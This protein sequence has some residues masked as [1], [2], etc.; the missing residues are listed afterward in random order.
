MFG[1]AVAALAMAPGLASADTKA[2]VGLHYNNL[3]SDAFTD[4]VDG[5][6]LDGAFN[7]DFSNGWTLQGDGSSDRLD[8]GGGGDL[9]VS[10][11]AINLGMRTDTH[12]IYG[13]VG[14]ADVFAASA[15]HIGIGGQLYMSN[16]VLEGSV[17]MADIDG[18][19][20]S[21]VN[22]SAG[23][24]WYFNDNLGVSGRVSHTDADGF[25]GPNDDYN[26]IG[27][28]GEYRF[29]NSPVSAFIGF[30]KN[31]TDPDDV[32]TWSLGM[33]VD[34]GSESLRDRQTHGPGWNGARTLYNDFFGGV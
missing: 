33:H 22:I 8:F 6:G 2:V 18:A 5:W 20:A 30:A 13:W 26:T 10:Y 9:G 15:T 31:D 34:L 16:L 3:D 24:T 11:S 12:A 7:Y 32:T 14:L 17:G 19:D 27:I 21:P 1:A 29:A 25:W 28:S 23:G 4:N